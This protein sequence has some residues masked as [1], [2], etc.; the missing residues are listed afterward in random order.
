MKKIKLTYGKYAIVDDEDYPILSRHK[1]QYKT[2]NISRGGV[3]HSTWKKEKAPYQMQDWIIQKKPYNQ[4]MFKNRNPLDL[5]KEN[6]YETHKGHPTHYG[7]KRKGNKTSKYKGVF[8]SK[9]DKMWIMAIQYKKS[10]YVKY[11]KDEKKAAKHYNKR[12]KEL[13][14]KLAYQNKI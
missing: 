12:A 4:I 9:K 3:V 7:F 10:R 11:F 14:G 8:W 1:W 13:Y 2:S 6:L 5:R